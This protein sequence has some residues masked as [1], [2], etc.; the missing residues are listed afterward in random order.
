MFNFIKIGAPLTF[1]A[2]D[3]SPI[4]SCVFIFLFVLILGSVIQWVNMKRIL[5]DRGFKLIDYFPVLISIATT[6]VLFGFF[7]ASNIS[8]LPAY[9]ENPIATTKPIQVYPDEITF[10]TSEQKTIVAGEDFPV[11]RYEVSST[12]EKGILFIRDNEGT[13]IVSEVIGSDDNNIPYYTITLTEGMSITMWEADDI[14]LNPVYTSES[15]ISAGEWT[16]GQDLMLE[17][18]VYEVTFDDPGSLSIFDTDGNEISKFSSDDTAPYLIV[19]KNGYKLRAAFSDSI[20]LRY[21]DAG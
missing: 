19:L 4:Q 17:E 1:S 15:T 3:V 8:T 5:P 6:I 18:G 10:S 7:N 12:S 9:V 13:K 16:I 11:G 2:F 20:N 21:T 14:T